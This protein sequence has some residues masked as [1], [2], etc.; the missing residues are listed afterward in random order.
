MQ[1]AGRGLKTPTLDKQRYSINTLIFVQEVY[2]IIYI[3]FRF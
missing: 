3:K 2:C 1:H